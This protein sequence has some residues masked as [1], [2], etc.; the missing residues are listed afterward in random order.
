MGVGLNSMGQITGGIAAAGIA[1]ATI[2]EMAEKNKIATA[3]AANKFNEKQLGLKQ[4]SNE[5]TAREAKLT[6]AQNA[7]SKEYDR[8]AGLKRPRKSSLEMLSRSAVELNMERAAIKT[9]WD[10]INQHRSALESSRKDLQKSMD[11]Y[12]IKTKLIGGDK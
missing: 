10:Q 2:G 7:Y 5:L 1:A 3:E 11:S 12:G 6:E 4:E 8:V 9:Q